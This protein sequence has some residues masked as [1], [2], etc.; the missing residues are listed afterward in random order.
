VQPSF[1][2]QAEK[3]ASS[4]ALSTPPRPKQAARMPPDCVQVEVRS[5]PVTCAKAPLMAVRRAWQAL[6]KPTR[7]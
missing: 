3:S 6:S 2:S 1:C 4:C 7:W 5:P